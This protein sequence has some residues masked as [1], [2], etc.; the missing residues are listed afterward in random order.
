MNISE[1]REFLLTGGYVHCDLPEDR[2]ELAKFIQDETGIRIGQ[3]PYSYMTHNPDDTTFMNVFLYDSGDGNGVRVSFRSSYKGET[4]LFDKVS[5]L[6]YQTDTRLDDRT[7]EEFA[8]DFAS[9]IGL[10][11]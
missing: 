11:R 5:H 1:F 7:E 8:K 4:I 3:G 2:N 10:Q 6:V 9:L